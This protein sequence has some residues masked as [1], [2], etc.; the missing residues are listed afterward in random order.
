VN[1]TESETTQVMVTHQEKKAAFKKC[2]MDKAVRHMD[3]KKLRNLWIGWVTV[4]N[5]LR[6]YRIDTEL[7]KDNLHVHQCRV[8]L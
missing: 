7:T 5:L 8:A 2:N 4:K 1:F 3:K 6:F